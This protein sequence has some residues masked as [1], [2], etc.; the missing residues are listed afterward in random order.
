MFEPLDFSYV[1]HRLESAAGM[2]KLPVDGLPLYFMRDFVPDSLCTALVSLIDETCEPSRVYP[3][4]RDS[5]FRTSATCYFR[6]GSE[7]V[8]DL[9]SRFVNL[10]GIPGVYGESAQGQRYFENEQFKP[11]LDAFP[12][13]SLSG[14][15]PH[16]QSQRTWTAMVYLNDVDQGGETHF[17]QI[18]FTSR[19]RKGNLL[20]WLN[21]F[22]NL[23]PNPMSVH[24][25]KTVSKGKKYIITKWYRT[26]PYVV[27]SAT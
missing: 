18:G 2:A 17:P 10:T 14:D 27:P 9:E 6:G 12:A 25:G 15:D 24:T 13:D 1:C 7:A 5:H 16:L 19:P 21:V 22:P 4:T 20:V 26:K 3:P 8:A 23:H 11:H